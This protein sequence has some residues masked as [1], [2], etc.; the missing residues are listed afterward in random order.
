MVKI[1]DV[2]A[3]AGVSPS[4]VSYAL[5]G[6]RSISAATRRRVMD[7][8][9]ELGYHP[10]AGAR[11]L[12]SNRSN[13]I[14]LVLP[15]RTG[16]HMPVLMQFAIAVVTAAREYD[17]DVLLLT[18]AEG[19]EGLER[20]ARGA[21]VDAIIVMDV[22]TDDVRVPVLRDLDRPSVLIGFPADP[23]GLVCI[24]LDFEA[25]GELCVDYLADLGCRTIALIGEPP[26]VYERGTGYAE[27]TMAGFQYAANRH[28]I[29]A[30]VRPCEPAAPAVRATIGRLLAEH[31]DLS[32]IVV[33]N[34]PAVAPMLE[35]LRAEGRRVPDDISIISV[36]QDDVAEG[37]TPPLTSIAIPAEEVGR[38]AVTLV[39]D[40]LDGRPARLATLIAPALVIRSSTGT[41]VPAA[42]RNPI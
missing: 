34:E 25:A 9:N 2:A 39:M 19:V 14:A 42:R 29:P 21:L 35:A 33:H 28:G 24:D 5:S 31:P 17:H 12:A 30:F 15:L 4:T 3:H 32:G 11:A 37:A 18:Q 10:H 13:V 7:A 27:R 36:G 22:E 20:V 40:Q 16:M 41:V 8:I 23:S 6:K 38:Q 1:S 26:E